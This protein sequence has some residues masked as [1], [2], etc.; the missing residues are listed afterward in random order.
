VVL[1]AVV[2]QR[3]GAQAYGG[4]NV[5]AQGVPLRGRHGQHA[6]RGLQHRARSCGSGSAAVSA[7]ACRW[8]ARWL[9]RVAAGRRDVCR[10]RVRERPLP[11]LGPGRGQQRR[12]LRQVR[13]GRSR[14]GRGR[15]ARARAAAP[16]ARRSSRCPRS[17]TGASRR[18]RRAASPGPRRR[19]ARAARPASRRGCWPARPAGVARPRSLRGGLVAHGGLPCKCAAPGASSACLVIVPPSRRTPGTPARRSSQPRCCTGRR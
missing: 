4:M 18:A 1:R 6:Q 17:P 13:P 9:R 16:H 5:Q 3:A 10:H 14:P 2:G 12:G 11:G 19:C 8:C 7:T 15:R